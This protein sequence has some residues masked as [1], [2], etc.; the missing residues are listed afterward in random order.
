M[1]VQ[2]AFSRLS[3]FFK[4]QEVGAGEGARRADEGEATLSSVFN[5]PHP[6]PLPHL[7]LAY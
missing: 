2:I 1:V 7:P 6:N 4:T 3:V 5:Y